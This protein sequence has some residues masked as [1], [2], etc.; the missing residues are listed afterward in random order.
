VAAQPIDDPDDLRLAD[1]RDLRDAELR[2]T[3]GLFAVEGRLMVERLLTTSRFRA[4]SVL[5][6]AE[7]VE[8]LRE[9]LAR[10][11]VQVYVTSLEL[12]R[13]LVGF[14]FHR[15]VL[16]LGER[17]EPAAVTVADSTRTVVGLE[18]VRDPENVGS[19]FRNAQAFAVGAVLLDAASGDPLGR[20]A[21]RVSAGAALT[22]PFAR[23][24]RW[25]AD[26][27]RLREAGFTIIALTPDPSA[28]DIAAVSARDRI[29]LVLGSEE[30]GLSIPTREAADVSAR[31]PMARGIDSLNV[32][33]AAGIA[34]YALRALCSRREES[35]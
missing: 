25:P 33:V 8:A 3:R 15:G 30:S 32:A 26:L 27:A 22:V 20:K 13:D 7:A 1:Y 19:V 24:G 35:A 18:D 10:S 6:T 17:D 29:A 9:P 4:R 31:I 2:R 5:G 34:L 16:A 28:P 23:A 21:I 11:A 12:I 14:K